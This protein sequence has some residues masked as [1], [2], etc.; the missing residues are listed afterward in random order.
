MTMKKSFS[1]VLTVIMSLGLLATP[2]MAT[3]NTSKANETSNATSNASSNTETAGV[4]KV[5]A[6][7]GSIVK[8]GI[9]QV[10]SLKKSKEFTDKGATAQA[11]VIYC[12][13]G[14][15]KD[16]KIVAIAIDNAQTKVAFNADGTLKTDVKAEPK[17]KRDLGDAYGMKEASGL[18]KEW[19][20]QMDA[21]EAW[22]IGKTVD[23]V[24]ALPVK[25]K[26]EAH[27]AVPDTPDLTSSVTISV[28]SYQAAIKEAVE[29]AVDV[30]GADNVGLGVMVSVAKSK[31]K[32]D[33]KGALAQMD[34]TG[35]LV[36][37]K[38]GKVAKV[39]LDVVQPKVEYEADGKLKTDVTQEVKSKVELGDAY[40]MK[41]ASGIKKE[42]FEQAKALEDWMA[43]KTIDEIKAIEVQDKDGKK[44]PSGADLV[45][46][47]T[48]GVADYLS[49]VEE[50]FNMA[51]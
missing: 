14:L 13:V 10:V 45:S 23:E 22:A 41:E 37:V 34:T 1:L 17:T 39:I 5:M 49:V 26:D 19:Y 4:K 12:A 47:V 15:D 43:G 38:D 20:E 6:E 33:T 32:T 8:A 21:F 27:P 42:W 9:S 31:A 11:D 3:S 48:V 25:A 16:G 44:V 50:A 28:E 46:S 40:G 24:M 35:A 7:K 30:D 29:R 51:K 36:A 2:V 18:K